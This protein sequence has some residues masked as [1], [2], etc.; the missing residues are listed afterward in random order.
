MRD[1][2]DICWTETQKQVRGFNNTHLKREVTI[3]NP[4]FFFLAHLKSKKEER[5]I[6]LWVTHYY[7]LLLL[8]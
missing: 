6:S 4:L 2:S 7:S 5:P 1:I 3:R 8:L